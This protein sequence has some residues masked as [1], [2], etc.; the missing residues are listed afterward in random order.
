SLEALTQ[1]CEASQLP[2]HRQLGTV[3][4]IPA[5]PHGSRS[6]LHTLGMIG[7]P[8]TVARALSIKAGLRCA[9]TAIAL[10]RYRQRTGRWPAFLEEVPKDLLPAIPLDPFDGKPLKY[11]H[12]DGG[13]TV[14]S[15]G[16]AELDNGGEV[17]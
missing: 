5:P 3:K 1:V 7:V 10:E 15:I 16:P 13:V 2:E 12:R 11:V 9:A 6:R 8:E 14:Y 17:G 4:A